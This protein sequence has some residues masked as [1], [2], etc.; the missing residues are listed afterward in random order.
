MFSVK[1]LLATAAFGAALLTA[2]MM[3]SAA[4]AQGNAPTQA[5]GCAS[6]QTVAGLQQRFN[7]AKQAG[8]AD[9][10][11]A[12]ASEIE[13]Y[14]SNQRNCPAN[15]RVASALQGLAGMV[16]AAL[17]QGVAPAAGDEQCPSL[18]DLQA[19][20]G[21]IQ[22]AKAAGDEER[23]QQIAATLQ[24][25]RSVAQ[26]CGLGAQE[27]AELERLSTLVLAGLE[28]IA[29]AAGPLAGVGLP[30]FGGAPIENPA[31]VSPN[32]P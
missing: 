22:A 8:N 15:P 12:V 17:E 14:Q 1:S 16:V 25:Y 5:I 24:N 10:L 23:L 6:D 9:A 31:Q 7:A 19:I 28:D 2:P 30:E 18:E 20:D 32:Q 3:A 4:P 11:T 27:L 26:S 21:A 13:V 29:P